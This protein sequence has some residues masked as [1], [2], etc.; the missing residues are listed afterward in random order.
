MTERKGFI[1]I[2]VLTGNARSIVFLLQ[3]GQRPLPPREE[4]LRDNRLVYKVLM[5][6][7]RP[8]AASILFPPTGSGRPRTNAF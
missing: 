6:A 2:L 3:D 1:G 7:S 4:D 5:V 8:H